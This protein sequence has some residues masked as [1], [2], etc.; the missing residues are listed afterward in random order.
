MRAILPGFRPAYTR[1]FRRPFPFGGPFLDA[2]Q[3]LEE[4]LAG[5]PFDGAQMAQALEP[6]D[7]AG[8]PQMARAL[9]NPNFRLFWSGNFLSN[10]G[11]W[12]ENVAR[13][14]LVLLL[15]NSA[16][17]WAW[18]VSPGRFRFCFSRSLAE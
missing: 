5:S 12:M 18:S 17:G 3:Q 6:D 16:S 13:G 11:T 8:Y 14:W 15:T 7:L 4:E 10:I 2:H 1:D 9:R